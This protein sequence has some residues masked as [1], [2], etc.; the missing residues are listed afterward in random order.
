MGNKMGT[1]KR[2]MAH[3][4]LAFSLLLSICF[5]LACSNYSHSKE[6][7]LSKHQL[8][9]I[10]N[11]IYKNETGAKPENLIAWNNGESFA[12][13]GIGH[14]IWFPPDLDS[15]FTETFPA[16]LDYFVQQKVSMPEWL[17]TTRDLP[18][19]TKQA[20]QNG[21]NGPKMQELQQLLLATF[22]HQIAF[23]QQRMR[24]ALP[25]MLKEL[26]RQNTSSTNIDALQQRVS[27]RFNLLQSNEQGLY[28]LIDYVNFK[29]EG[30]APKE[31]YKGQGWGLLQ[32]LLNIDSAESVEEALAGFT[33][34]CKDVLARRVD[35]SPQRE[36]EQRWTAGWN[37]RCDTYS[38]N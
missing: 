2:S 17:K 3:H 27:E 30:T 7:V 35:N 12:S 29:G 4:Q 13:L 25:T 18:W 16:L 19:K 38:S 24:R 5:L 23:I 22:D 1:E 37:K 34:A 33:Q 26:E 21:R 6:L 32:V 11:K 15:P 14:F 36:I 20:F 28:A 10:G 8:S 9:S 31:R